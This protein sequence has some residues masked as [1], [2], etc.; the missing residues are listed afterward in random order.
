[1]ACQGLV[2]VGVA[3]LA[4]VVTVDRGDMAGT[5]MELVA[6]TLMLLSGVSRGI[7]FGIVQ[8]EECGVVVVMH[9]L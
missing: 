2:N 4:V 6:A 3:S 5:L 1:M 7:V 9:L 8:L